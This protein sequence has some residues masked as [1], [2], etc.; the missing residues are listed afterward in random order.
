M[1]KTYYVYLLTNKW[2]HVL[3]VGVTSNLS[4]RIWE[5]R[6]KV[7]DGFSK[8]YNL[9]YLVYYEEWGDV[10]SAIEREK[11]IKS[12]SRQKKNRLVESMNPTWKD[13]YVNV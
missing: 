12:W 1:L 4:K 13:L 8:R 6:E 3:Y 10:M 5:H 9:R 2:N 7:V 11:Q